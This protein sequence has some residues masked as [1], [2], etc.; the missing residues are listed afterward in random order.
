MYSYFGFS[1]LLVLIISSDKLLL[2]SSVNANKRS[3]GLR[4]GSW[5]SDLNVIGS[6]MAGKLGALV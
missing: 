4:A 2:V 1:D 3:G 6:R 5:F